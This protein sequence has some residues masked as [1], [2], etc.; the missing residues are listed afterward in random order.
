VA[1]AI[2]IAASILGIVLVAR[3]M[4]RLV[5]HARRVGRGDLSPV[6]V[7]AGD[8]EIAQL[9]REMNAM[10]AQLASAQAA[11]L[12]ALE[13]LRRAE[14]LST[15]GTLA[16]GLAH[17]LGTPLNVIALRAKAIA[18]GRATGDRAQEAATS[19]AEQAARMTNLVRQLL[20]F[21]RRRAPQRDVV[22]V[23]ELMRRTADLMETVAAKA[24]VRCEVAHSGSVPKVRGDAGQL[25][26]VLTN[27]SMNAIQAMP[28]GG[29]IHI[30]AV[31]VEATPPADRGGPPA[32]Y[33]R[34]SVRDEGVGIS[35]ETLP[36]IFEPFFTTKDVG[37]GTG[38][39][40]AVCYGI[41]RD[42]AGWL[43]VRS[44]EGKGAEL[45]VYLPKEPR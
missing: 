34:I 42:H 15:V 23:G 11:N 37:V 9:A 26:Q 40:L 6:T 43:D 16:S 1:L 5:A 25:E 21:A 24:N 22:D 29:I 38:L 32:E 35:A 17:E 14:R 8:D 31:V 45:C 3:P 7:S 18:K 36:H 12:D 27:L 33:V 39:G 10:C 30:Q 44:V 28:A 2:G 20:D 4:R 19:I 41:V 13:Q